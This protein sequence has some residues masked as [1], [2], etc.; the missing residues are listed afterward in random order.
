MFIVDIADVRIMGQ[1]WLQHD[2]NFP[3]LGIQVEEPCDANLIGHWKLDEGTGTFAE[4]S[5]VNDNN[6]TVEA[7]DEGGYS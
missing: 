3:D 1:Q 7:T 6:G 4:D 5:S 2:V